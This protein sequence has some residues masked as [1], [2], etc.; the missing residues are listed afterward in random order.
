MSSSGSAFSA[1]F[2]SAFFVTSGSVFSALSTTSGSCS[3]NSGCSKQD[4][5]C[6][7]KLTDRCD[8]TFRT[9]YIKEYEESVLGFVNMIFKFIFK[10]INKELNDEIVKIANENAQVILYSSENEPTV[11]G[12][13]EFGTD[14]VFEF[15]TWLK[16]CAH[17]EKVEN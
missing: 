12:N 3:G 4:G 1:T 16:R 8:I 17:N 13:E 7:S 14:K 15:L 6:D 5:S 11:E 9:I 10:D 2:G